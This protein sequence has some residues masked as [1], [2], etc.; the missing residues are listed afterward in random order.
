MAWGQIIIAFIAGMFLGPW[1]LSMLTGKGKQSSQA[2][3]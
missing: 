1:A 3:Y 2:G